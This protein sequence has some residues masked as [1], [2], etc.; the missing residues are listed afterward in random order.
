MGTEIEP[1]FSAI[2]QNMCLESSVNKACGQNKYTTRPCTWRNCHNCPIRTLYILDTV[3]WLVIF[4]NRVQNYKLSGFC[5]LQ[6][7]I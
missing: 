6:R 4:R 5:M 3:I 1:N 7:V 2:V